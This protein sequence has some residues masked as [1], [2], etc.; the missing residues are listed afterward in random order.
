MILMRPVITECIGPIFTKFS[1]LVDDVWVDMIS[2][3][4]CHSFCDRS[5]DV[6]MVTN[7]VGMAARAHSGL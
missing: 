6:A 5:R 4:I 7:L 1:G 3:I 2:L